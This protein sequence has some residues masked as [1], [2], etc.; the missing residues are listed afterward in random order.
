M[1]FDIDQLIENQRNYIKSNIS[2]WEEEYPST[3]ATMRKLFPVDKVENSLDAFIAEAFMFLNGHEGGKINFGTMKGPVDV[4]NNTS[5]VSRPNKL[6]GSL[7]SP[8]AVNDYV[9][10]I[11]GT[12]NHSLDNINKEGPLYT[13]YFHM[14][15][16]IYG[17]GRSDGSCLMVHYSQKVFRDTL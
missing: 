16:P 17:V 6:R 15:L 9:N 13:Y 2:Y 14:W 4:I 12:I 10:S 7:A 1:S 11:L 3:V 8:T 5:V